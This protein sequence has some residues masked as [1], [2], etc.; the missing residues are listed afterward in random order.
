[1]S[2]LAPPP[3]NE[4]P[5]DQRAISI[6]FRWF[7]FLWYRVGEGEAPTNKEMLRRV[8]YFSSF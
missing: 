3:I 4:Q 8:H 2:T 7:Q 6:W 1:M 5:Q